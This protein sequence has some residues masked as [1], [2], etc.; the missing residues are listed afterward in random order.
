[1]P[2][3]QNP[4]LHNLRSLKELYCFSNKIID[5][6]LLNFLKTAYQL[7]ILDIRICHLLT[8]EVL[9]AVVELIK[10]RN[11]E[12]ILYLKIATTR[13]NQNILDEVPK[14]L[15]IDDIDD[16]TSYNSFDSETI[17]CDILVH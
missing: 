8:F 1:M 2:N 6:C 17:S 4:L 11:N 9:N 13:I 14:L 5:K 16:I 15:N 12:K 7:Q 3:I 10:M